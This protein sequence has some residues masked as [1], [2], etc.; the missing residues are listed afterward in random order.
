[1][2]IYTHIRMHRHIHSSLLPNA[3][4]KIQ[5]PLFSN[6]L[7]PQR[8]FPARAHAAPAAYIERT[9]WTRVS[10]KWDI[11]DTDRAVR[12]F[13]SISCVRSAAD[14]VGRWNGGGLAGLASTTRKGT[15][16]WSRGGRQPAEGS[17]VWWAGPEI[18]RVRT[19]IISIYLCAGLAPMGRRCSPT[20]R[21][22][23]PERVLDYHKQSRRY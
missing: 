18:I 5:Q 4:Q 14:T 17:R 6:L 16:G 11:Q 9:L 10:A 21:S 22:Q 8:L 12:R 2:H 3:E 13:Q 15:P 1:M 19:C 7:I 23:Q 20:P